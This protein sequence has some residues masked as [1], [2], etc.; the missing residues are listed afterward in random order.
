MPNKIG[1]EQIC[2]TNERGLISNNRKLNMVPPSD[3]KTLNPQPQIF[4]PRCQ[5]QQNNNNLSKKK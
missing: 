1:Y 2:Q 4:D 5:S 3:N